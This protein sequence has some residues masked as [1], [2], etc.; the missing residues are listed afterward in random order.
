MRALSVLILAAASALTAARA[1]TIQAPE[2]GAARNTLFSSVYYD[3]TAPLA[4]SRA[5]AAAG[6]FATPIGSVLGPDSVFSTNRVLDGN[7]SVGGPS[8][9]DTIVRRDGA[10]GNAIPG[11]LDTSGTAFMIARGG[12]PGRPMC[13]GCADLPASPPS[14]AENPFLDGSA[15][16]PEPGP[17]GPEGSGLPNPPNSG[18]GMTDAPEPVPFL[19][20]GLGLLSL[21][22]LRRRRR[23]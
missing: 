15:V 18:P 7:E 23:T 20:A 13:P 8:G 14:G 1:T 2:S 9:G 12:Q 6:V 11:A 19:L 16:T 17:G 5:A 4:A 21:G 10:R 22:V 3:R